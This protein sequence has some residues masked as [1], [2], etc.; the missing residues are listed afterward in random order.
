MK[1][2]TKKSPRGE[3]LD[4]PSHR[5]LPGQTDFPFGRDG[6]DGPT[7]PDVRA[8]EKAASDGPGDGPMRP[9]ADGAKPEIDPFD[10]NSLRLSQD[11]ASAVGVKR[12]IKTVPVKKPA[13]EWFVRT[14]PTDRLPTAVLELKEDREIYL[15]APELRAE[16]ASETTF[17]PRLLVLSVNRQGVPFLWPIRLPGPDG[18][19]D[20]WSRSAM[21]AAEEAQR[22]WVRITA[23]LSLGAYD[24]TAA[25]G[26]V[27][28]PAWPDISFQEIIRIA[29]RDKMISDWSHPVLQRLRGEV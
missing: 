4:P 7:A 19:I 17:S 2:S 18:R 29:F 13:R 28:E 20:D 6:A 26:L 9:L 8:D 16:L 3:R 23:N 5:P 11:F 21:D 25:S 10:L 15:V 22:Q 24:V 14:H 12:L 27:A 1:D